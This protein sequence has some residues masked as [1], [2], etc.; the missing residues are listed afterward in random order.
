MLFMH[1]T[2]YP[3]NRVTS[4]I[5]SENQFLPYVKASLEAFSNRDRKK[6]IENPLLGEK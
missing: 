4:D 5:F 1:W 3:P 6:K 2:L